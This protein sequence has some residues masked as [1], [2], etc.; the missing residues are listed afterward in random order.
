MGSYVGF[1]KKDPFTNIDL[2]RDKTKEIQ[3]AESMK[4]RQSSNWANQSSTAIASPERYNTSKGQ[5]F[6]QS[7]SPMKTC[8]MRSATDHISV[9][10]PPINRPFQKIYDQMLTKK[11][12]SINETT[13]VGWAPATTD[14]KTINNRSSVK[15][16]IINHDDNKTSG[17]MVIGTLDKKVTNKK[18]GIGEYADLMRVT[19]VNVNHEY[20]S[21]AGDSADGGGETSTTTT[22]VI[23]MM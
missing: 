3:A 14:N 5:N 19:S 11:P 17:V 22:D 1:L 9:E 8:P 7:V 23:I 4:L 16:N 6:S 15:H 21:V 2:H 18:K 20:N 12:Y 10:P 13:K